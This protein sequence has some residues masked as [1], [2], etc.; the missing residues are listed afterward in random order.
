M[1]QEQICVS[2]E[3]AK[4]LHDAG[5]ELDTHFYWYQSRVIGKGPFL[6]VFDDPYLSINDP[7][8]LCYPAPTA[9]EL[10][11]L[12]PYLIDDGDYHLVVDLHGLDAVY[13]LDDPCD[14]GDAPLFYKDI[15]IKASSLCELFAKM[16]I[17]LK[18]DGAI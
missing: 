6:M 13:I 4:A 14:I 5:I 2:F 18:K 1:T 12:L 15:E 10:R 8:E 3:T 17:A 16:L 7:V 11:G 9:E